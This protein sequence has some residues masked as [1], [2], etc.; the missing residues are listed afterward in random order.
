MR[1]GKT[2][3]LKLVPLPLPP[4]EQVLET[5]VKL[6]SKTLQLERGWYPLR[7]PPRGGVE[8]SVDEVESGLVSVPPLGT[9]RG[10]NPRD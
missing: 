10:L 4:Q 2:F 3:P 6:S 8:R 5:P 7:L 9:P 1:L